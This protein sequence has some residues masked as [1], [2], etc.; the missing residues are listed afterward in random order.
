MIYNNH[1][2]Y[3]KALERY[4]ATPGKIINGKGFNFVNG[5]WVKDKEYYAHNSKPTYEP[6]PKEN[7]DKQNI[8]P[9]IKVKRR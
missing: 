2:S 1:E 5:K 9:S 6:M 3:L 7:S 8:S 4:M